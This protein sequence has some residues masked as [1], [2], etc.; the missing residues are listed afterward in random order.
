[1]QNIKYYLANIIENVYQERKY[2]SFI[3]S[4]IYHGHKAEE[5]DGKNFHWNSV[6]FFTFSPN[7]NVKLFHLQ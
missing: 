2:T 5:E 4:L 1:M 6:A 7:I 3:C